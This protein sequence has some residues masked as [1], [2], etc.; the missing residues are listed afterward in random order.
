MDCK[1]LDRESLR[2]RKIFRGG[3]GSFYMFL[4]GT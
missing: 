4:V 3:G 2:S 1:E